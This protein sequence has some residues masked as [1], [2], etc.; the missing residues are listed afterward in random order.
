MYKVILRSVRAAV[1]AVEKQSVLIKYEFVLQ[2]TYPACKAYA[3]YCSIASGLSG[4]TI[5]FHIMWK[6][7]R[8]LEKSY[9]T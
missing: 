6:T 4:C 3:L 5:F 1:V 2:P 9:W 7:A 8:F